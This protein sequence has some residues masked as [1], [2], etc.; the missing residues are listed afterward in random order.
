[1]TEVLGRVYVFRSK[2]VLKKTRQCFLLNG[3]F[4]LGRC[5]PLK[6]KSVMLEDFFLCIHSEKV[7][8]VLTILCWIYCGI[9]SDF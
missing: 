3:I 5:R 4:F 8:V 9:L 1:M 6:P 2:R 7:N